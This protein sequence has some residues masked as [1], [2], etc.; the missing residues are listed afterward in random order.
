MYSGSAPGLRVLLSGIFI[1][2]ISSSALNIKSNTGV[3]QQL[4]RFCEEYH[5][6]SSDWRDQVY[7]IIKVI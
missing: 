4:K 2:V 6:G 5:M 7:T 3:H 1:V